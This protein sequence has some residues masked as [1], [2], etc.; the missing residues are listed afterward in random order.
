MKEKKP[1]CMVEKKEVIWMAISIKEVDGSKCKVVNK[2]A[3]KSDMYE[4]V[5]SF[6][7]KNNAIFNQQTAHR[8]RA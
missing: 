1:L 3:K 5:L 7:E 8:L 6:L 4:R 2:K